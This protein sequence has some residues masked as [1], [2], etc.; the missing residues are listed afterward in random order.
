MVSVIF[1]RWT[2]FIMAVMGM[3]NENGT[4]IIGH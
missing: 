4:F 1:S 3:D 2:L